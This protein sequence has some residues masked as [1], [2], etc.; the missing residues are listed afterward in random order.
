MNIIGEKLNIFIKTRYS[1]SEEDRVV[2][3]LMILFQ[4]CPSSLLNAFFNILG[5]P[6]DQ[7]ENVIIKEHIPYAADSILDSE[8]IVPGKLL[9]AVE[10]KIYEDQFKDSDQVTKYF[11]I[12]KEKMETRRILL[13]ISPDLH[14]PRIVQD[15]SEQDSSCFIL[16]RKWNQIFSLIKTQYEL[17]DDLNSA[18]SYLI[19]EFLQYLKHLNLIES[20]KPAKGQKRLLEPQLHFLFGNIAVE[21]IFL[22]LFH[23]GRGHLREIVRDHDLGLGSAQRVLPRLVKSGILK[24]ERE[25]NQIIYSFNENSPLLPSILDMIR[26]V[27]KDIPQNIK[28]RLFNPSYSRKK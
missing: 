22:H 19:E 24:K 6:I 9:V 4:Q 28:K 2:N 11:E 18:A 16:W 26:V 3:G 25:G 13:L 17:F 14:K 27:Y 15:I 20:Q 5:F 21:K 8:L 1:L 12:L 7:Q 10:A 23:H